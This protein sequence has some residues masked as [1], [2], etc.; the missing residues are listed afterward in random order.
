MRAVS[1]RSAGVCAIRPATEL[2]KSSRFHTEAWPQ[3]PSVRGCGRSAQKAGPL[4]REEPGIATL[5]NWRIADWTEY[6]R[7]VAQ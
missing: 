4:A 2:S 3:S 7:T 1:S 5:A 6:L